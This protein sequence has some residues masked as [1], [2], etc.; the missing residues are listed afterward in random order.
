MY[1]IKGNVLRISVRS[2]VEFIYRTGSID[3]RQGGMSDVKLMQEGTRMHKKIQKSMGSSYHAEVPL[4]VDL[5][6]EHAEHPDWSGEDYYI[7][8]EGRA[9]GIICDLDEQDDGEKVPLTE[10]TI[11]EIKTVQSDVKKMEQPVY[12]HIAQARCY[13]YIYASQNHL[14]EI[15][16][17]LTY[18]NPETEEVRRFPEKMSYEELEKWFD[19]TLEL[20]LRWSDFLFEERKKRTESIQGLDFPFEYR[21]GQKNLVVNVYKAIAQEK[22]L[23][24]QAPTGVG[25]TISTVFPAVQAMGQ[26]TVDKIFYLTSKTITRTVAED[27]FAILRD[28]GLSFRAVTLTAK[29]KICILKE[30]DCNPAACE[31]ADGHYDRV[32]DA[33]YDL[34]SH[35]YVINRDRIMEYAG[36]HKVCPF[37]MSLDVSYWCDGII[38]DYNYVFDPNVALKRYFGDG[39]KGDYVFLVDEAHNLVDRARE[40]YSATLKKEDFLKIKKSVKDNDKKLYHSLE[41]CNKDLLEM[42]RLCDSYK[43]LESLGHFPMALERCFA[44]MQTFLEKHKSHPQ[45]DEIVDFFFAVRH[46]L[47]M[48][49]NLDEK[50]VKYTEHDK[51]G[52]F[53]VHLYCVDPSGNISLRLTQGRSTVF[54]SATLLPIGYFKEMLSGDTDDY[55][56]YA[57][58]SFD[59]ANRRVAIARDVS[60]R[61]TRRNTMEFRK[62][63]EYIKQ[64]VETRHGNYMVFFPSYSFM[65]SV[66]DEFLKMYDCTE[67]DITQLRI[68]AEADELPEFAGQLSLNE[69]VGEK[70]VTEQDTSKDSQSLVKLTGLNLVMQDTYMKEQDKEHFLE[71]FAENKHEA[72]LVGFCVTGGIFSEGIDLKEDSLIGAV[73]VGTGLPMICRERNILKEYFDEFGKDGYSYAYVFPGMNKVL[74]AA[75]RVIRTDKDRGVIVLLDDRFMT[76]E[77]EQLFPREWDMIYPVNKSLIGGVLDEF[78]KM[79]MQ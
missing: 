56:V 69:I 33:V 61:Y 14:D 15:T 46:W 60:S 21:E 4:K 28:R 13:A 64:T 34:V 8:L 32:N 68:A 19:H 18:C 35:E 57:Q 73:I 65:R 10:V 70:E 55:A 74:Q 29:D 78:W 67:L 17:Q 30:R 27:T 53:L 54:F 51:D 58:S 66:R 62:I 38:C 11:D 6:V 39:G 37:E 1:T 9:D 12:V 79:E 76:P 5:P 24:I 31:Y 40:M 3:N 20:F 41:R 71:L 63:C 2:L 16:V 48:Y 50:Y 36:K 77:Y 25:K 52:D 75:G 7:R 59:T 26:Q 44:C 23:Y 22:N 45:M 42:K 72:T 47:N 43:V 49:D